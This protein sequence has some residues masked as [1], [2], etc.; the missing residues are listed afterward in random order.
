MRLGLSHIA[1]K[2]GWTLSWKNGTKKA[3]VKRAG[4]TMDSEATELSASTELFD[5]ISRTFRRSGD[6][7]TLRAGDHTATLLP[8]GKVLIA[9]GWAGNT[10]TA[11]AELYDPS[12]RTFAPTGAMTVRRAGQTA[13]LLPS[14]K[15]L[16]VGGYGGLGRHVMHAAVGDEHRAGA[17][18]RR[19]IGERFIGLGADEV[20]NRGDR[21]LRHRAK[22]QRG[23]DHQLQ[24][25]D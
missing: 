16:F 9:G 17:A 20:D 15:V 18:I 13:T 1:T 14:G 2:N 21:G 24:D 25:Q 4:E 3:R 12:S 19:H 22:R 7:R 10:P 6:M 11:E 5:P 23:R 8:T